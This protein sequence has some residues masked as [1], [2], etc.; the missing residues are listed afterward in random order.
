VAGRG[1]GRRVR[2][3]AR[4]RGVG[5]RSDG[6]RTSLDL[7][8][9]R[10]IRRSIAKPFVVAYAPAKSDISSTVR[11]S[12]STIRLNSAL[13]RSI[14]PISRRI[15]ANMSSICDGVSTSSL[16]ARMYRCHSSRWIRRVISSGLMRSRNA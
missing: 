1:G 11:T 14:P 2:V 8:P 13:R 12:S 3:F 9:G 15:R 6:L 7:V 4:R 16:L 10:G 5:V